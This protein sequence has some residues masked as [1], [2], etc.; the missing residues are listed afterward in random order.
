MIKVKVEMTGADKLIKVLEG[1]PQNIVDA[2]IK[3]QNQVAS[4]ATKKL[5]RGLGLYGGAYGSKNYISSEIGELPR[6]HSGRLQN[7]IFFKNIAHKT[8]VETKMGSMIASP[9]YAKY[10]EGKNGDGIRPFLHYV[11]DIFNFQKVLEYFNK[12]YEPFKKKEGK[13]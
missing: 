8:S 12:Y 1:E 2:M 11:K 3:A 4:L 7:S 13:A 9:F 5:K 6:K 10:L